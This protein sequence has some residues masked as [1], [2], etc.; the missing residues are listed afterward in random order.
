MLSWVH[1]ELGGITES[2]GQLLAALGN[3]VR[4]I[5]AQA[6]A[7]EGSGA[8]TAIVTSIGGDPMGVRA[9]R[10]TFSDDVRA[11]MPTVQ[12]IEPLFL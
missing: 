12:C 4:Q 11:T 1:A 5:S 9:V 2:D 8:Y 10:L 3:E 6:T 7:T